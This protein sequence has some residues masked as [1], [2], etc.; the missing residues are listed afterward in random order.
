MNNVLAFIL[1]GGQGTRLFPLTKY[2]S[3]PAVPVAGKFRLVDIPV[4]NCINSD[5]KKIAVITQF[6]SESLN[7]GVS[8]TYK[9][10]TFS[11]GYIRIL[12][13]EQTPG[14]NKWLQGTADAIRQNI[15]HISDS[16]IEYA[17]ILS[18]DQLYRMDYKKMY[19]HHKSTDAYS[20]LALTVTEIE[21]ASEFG[22]VNINA[23]GEITEFVEKPT[24][25]DIINQF[26]VSDV[27][28]VEHGLDMDRD[29]VLANMGIY[30]F[31]RNDLQFLMESD[32]SHDFGKGIYPNLLGEKKLMS[33]IHNGYWEDI[34]TIKAF[35]HANL[36]I[37]QAHPKFNFYDM[38]NP[39]YA[40]PR[41]LPP[42]KF[43]N[44]NVTHSMISDGCILSYATVIES[45]LGV[46][47]MIGHNSI[48]ECSIIM[49]AD[50]YEK[51][52]PRFDDSVSLGIGQN[53]IIK[54]AIID[55]NVRIGHGV[56]IINKDQH[57]DY[58]GGYYMIRDG[59][60]VVEKDAIIP[61]GTII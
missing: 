46:R 53:C 11:R 15:K 8:Q 26:K 48:I 37:G 5:I 60:V 16:D 2:R 56:Q 31:N 58:D 59:I 40:E 52:G 38:D 49:G 42:S 18:G 4:S 36:E 25:P 24:D 45:S 43:E 20:T 13:A 29:Y 55:K 47:T 50:Y 6:N 27:V 39:I 34:G 28:K 17:L 3:K 7:R 22:L 23:E 12:A 35:Y 10:D 61:D 30:I 33:F 19:R 32:D 44:C 14:N 54:D 9:F 57:E 51:S 21:K 41:F 1:G